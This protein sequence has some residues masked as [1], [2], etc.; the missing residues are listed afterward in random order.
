MPGGIAGCCHG[1]VY[2]VVEWQG[3]EGNAKQRP[4]EVA[5]AAACLELVFLPARQGLPSCSEASMYSCN[6]AAITGLTSPGVVTMLR[7]LVCV[8]FECF[9]KCM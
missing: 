7:L 8:V 2:A 1:T 4:A 9:F 3:Q 6:G 5:A